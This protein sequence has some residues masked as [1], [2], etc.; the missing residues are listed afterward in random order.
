MADSI[1]A[2]MDGKLRTRLRLTR[3]GMFAALAWAA[4]VQPAWT[5]EPEADKPPRK[6]ENRL[7]RETSPYLLLHK[8]NPVDWY[9]WGTE[10]LAKAKAENKLIFLS[11]GYSSC[12]W[13]HVME[14]ESFMDDQIASF[15]NEHF[16]CIK[17]DREERPDVDEIY[18]MA[19]AVLGRRG[20]WPLTM[21]LTPDAK[22]IFGGTYFPPRDKEIV[23]PAGKDGQPGEPQR[24]T[25]LLK[26]L[27]LVHDGWKESPE[28]L[29][30]TGDQI[31]REVRRAMARH[32][33]APAGPPP[34]ELAAKVLAGLSGIYDREHGGFGYSAANPQQPKFPEPPNLDFLIE[35]ARRAPDGSARKMLVGTLEAMAAGGIRDHVGGGFHRYSTDRFWRIPHFEKMLYDNGQLASVYAEAFALTGRE[36]FKQVAVEILAFVSRELADPAGGF[37]AALDAETDAEEG[38]YYVWEREELERLLSKDEFELLSE[39]YGV[40]DGPNFEDRSVLLLSRPLGE[41]AARRMLSLEELSARLAPIRQKLLD[42]RGKRERPLTDTK[43][44]TDWNGLVI[45]GFADAGRLLDDDAYTEAAA[46][47]ADFI[48]KNSR[49]SEGRLWH[50]NTGGQA[51]LNAYLDDYAMFVDGLI[52]LHRATGDTRW[53]TAADELTQLQIKLFWD[54]AAG[55]F[56]FT[57]GDHEALIARG[58]DPV[59]GVVPAGNAVAADNLVYLARALSKPEYLERAERT[60]T[61]FAG[62]LDQSP[63]AMPRMATAWTKLLEAKADGGK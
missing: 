16:V 56:F 29:L 14:R 30:S 35:Y 46:G 33:L 38:L 47:A 24:M 5:S 15:L 31:A 25:G 49:T 2:D 18:M 34:E 19:L 51:H 44:L 22:P 45:R 48:L 40:A 58:K 10:A 4:C 32:Q 53:L 7:A 57:S 43:I 28:Q 59:D 12:Y 54:D 61:A 41:T 6:R 11:I 23:P 42:A 8:H 55:G 27:E 39:T 50:A 37:Y 13:C 9:P 20:G 17:V 52:A 36:D 60:V 3:I 62:W 21:F 26:V 1:L 63:A